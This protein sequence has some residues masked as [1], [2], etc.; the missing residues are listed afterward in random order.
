MYRALNSALVVLIF[1]LLLQLLCFGCVKFCKGRFDGKHF[2]LTDQY[3]LILGEV[4]G[5]SQPNDSLWNG[6][7]TVRGVCCRRQCIDLALANFVKCWLFLR[8]F[9]IIEDKFRLWVTPV[10]S[11]IVLI[12]LHQIKY[13]WYSIDVIMFNLDAEVITNGWLHRWLFYLCLFLVSIKAWFV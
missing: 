9:N 12:I 3:F 8:V 6:D 1:K 11:R 4:L 5:A 2:W 10:T 13:W 7:Y